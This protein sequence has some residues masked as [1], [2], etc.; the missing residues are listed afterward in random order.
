M[1]LKS[2]VE[3]IIKDD[4]PC[5]DPKDVIFITNKWDTLCKAAV[6][7]SDDSDSEDE[8]TTVW[9]SVKSDIK[10]SWMH[11]KDENIFKLSLKDVI[12]LNINQ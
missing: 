12:I 7:N 10:D 3:L 5:F 2:L 1:I 4:M 6:E 8:A 11:V 9:A